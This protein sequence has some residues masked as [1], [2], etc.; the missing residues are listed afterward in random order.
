MCGA[1]ADATEELPPLPAN[2]PSPAFCFPSI[3]YT[4]TF[5]L[6]HLE[7]NVRK[8]IHYTPTFNLSP[9][10][11][12]SIHYTFAFNLRHLDD[13]SFGNKDE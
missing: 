5:N 12:I 1:T 11:V 2:G 4:S 9:I 8:T 10:K 3:H 7:D 6:R 13:K